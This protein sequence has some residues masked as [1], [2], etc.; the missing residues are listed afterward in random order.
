MKIKCT[1]CGAQQLVIQSDFFLR[2][3]YCDSRIIV[4][5][6]EDSPAL[7]ESCVSEEHVRRL[8]P[9]GMVSSVQKMY[10]PYLETATS[11][12]RETRLCFNQPWLELADYIPPSGDR[13]IFDEDLA[14]PGQLIPF[15]RDVVEGSGG[16]V[17]FHPFYIVML[18]LEGYGEGL[19]VDAVSGK[20]ISDPPVIADHSDSDRKL[21]R[22]FFITLAVGLLFTVPIYLLTKNMDLSWLSR[23]WTF[24]VIIPL[25]VMFYHYRI[26]NGGG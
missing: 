9:S 24:I 14:D 22:T 15:D 8:F 2:C 5:P 23:V 21:F 12:G 26:R 11:S 18:E 13:K 1:Q 19:L 20:L 10:F 25:I 4:D 17:V 7:V 3:S 16:R 6:P